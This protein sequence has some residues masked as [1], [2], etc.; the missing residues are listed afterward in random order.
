MSKPLGKILAITLLM[1]VGGWLA[2][3]RAAAESP[4]PA[5]TI[6]FAGYDQLSTS[7]KA[8]DQIDSHLELADKFTKLLSAATNGHNLD[9]LDKS[10]PW[11]ILVVVGESD[12]PTSVGYL[13][14]TSLKKLI[15]GLPL[16]G[17]ETPEPNS[18]GVYE[19]PSAGKT[20]YVKQKGSWAVLSDNDE[21]LDSA[22][23]DPAPLLS[24]L[25]KKYLV[26]VRG[27]VQN[28]PAARR[29]QF[30]SAMRGMAQFFM[31]AQGG[32]DEQCA[33][34]Q[35]SLKQAFDQLDKLS[36]E[37][38][39]LVL[40]LGVDAEA[41]SIYFDVE[42]R[43][44]KDTDLAARCAAM[45]DA[46][47]N[48]AG[49]AV[50]GAAMTM[51]SASTTDKEQVTQAKAMLDNV[52]SATT[53]QLDENDE[54]G[55]KRRDLAK[56]LLGDVFEVAKKTLDLGKSDGAIAVLLGD[57]PAVIG[58]AMIADGKK[59]KSA[60]HKLAKEV[61][62]ESPDLAQMIK[63]DAEEYEGI[64]FDEATVPV[65]PAG[66]AREVLGD[67]VQIA[68]GISDSRIYIGA[69]KEPIAAIKKA[70]DA[71]KDDPDKS[72]SP[73]EM[74]ISTAPIA[75]FIADN[76]PKSDAGKKKAKKLAD[77]VAKLKNQLTITLKPVTDGTL[78]RV[79]V[80]PGALKT[81]VGLLYASPHI[82][83]GEGDSSDE[84]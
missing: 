73:M 8:V 7:L 50:P 25:T 55:D 48:F 81:V 77:Q 23:A 36:K 38:D 33:M 41:K 35:A 70:I 11:G 84:N 46:K 58:G 22:A 49:F 18:K 32:S 14:V 54:L 47:T 61:Q 15:A 72:I 59:L 63:L 78:M 31:A 82:S 17:G 42:T 53:K 30:L 62:S 37:L 80:E 24:D 29:D 40:G 52:K 20:I 68:V 44:L 67:S 74:V 3:D 76:A 60:L 83:G 12:E 4:K 79:T 1:A 13:P 9:G 28:V 45:K 69:G 43:A 26:G 66:G 75:K 64:K 16:P 57:H 34:Q 21:A 27:N 6:A 5:L 56:Q 2:S 51:L 65:P 10:R 39:T 71:S 19:I